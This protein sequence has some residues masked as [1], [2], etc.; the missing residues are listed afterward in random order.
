MRSAAAAWKECDKLFNFVETWKVF[1]PRKVILRPKN[2]CC[3]WPLQWIPGQAS[4]ETRR[5]P[6]M[7]ECDRRQGANLR[8]CIWV[9][10]LFD[11]RRFHG[12]DA[13]G[14]QRWSPL[15]R[16]VCLPRYYLCFGCVEGDDHIQRNEVSFLRMQQ[17]G[18]RVYRC[19]HQRGQAEFR[20]WSAQC[21]SGHFLIDKMLPLMARALFHRMGS[22]LVRDHNSQIH[23]RAL[24]KRDSDDKLLMTRRQEASKRQ[25]LQGKEKMNR[26]K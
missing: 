25:R 6:T 7:P 13:V 17:C 4:F 11:S 15:S 20:L 18:K 16:H 8:P 23:A 5:L 14:R 2:R 10:S 21:S 9:G 24:D 26:L 1:L 3:C 19:F 12:D 22:N